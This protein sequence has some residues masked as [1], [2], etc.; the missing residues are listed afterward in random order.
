VY[1]RVSLAREI[2]NA[3][4]RTYRHCYAIILGNMANSCGGRLEVAHLE[5]EKSFIEVLNR[6][7]HC[8]NVSLMIDSSLVMT[9]CEVRFLFLN[10]VQVP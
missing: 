8:I 7:Y 10:F 1:T 2:L 3:W 5:I 6:M 4:N 9:I